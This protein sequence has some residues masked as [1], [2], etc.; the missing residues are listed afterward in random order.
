V[1]RDETTPSTLGYRSSGQRSPHL[2]IAYRRF[3]SLDAI[4]LL[5]SMLWTLA[6]ARSILEGVAQ[7]DWVGVVFDSLM[8][9]LGVAVAS[10]FF[11]KLL[12]QSVIALDLE[13]ITSRRGPFLRRKVVPIGQVSQLV[14]T[15]QHND[16][17][18]YSYGLLLQRRDGTTTPLLEPT[19]SVE[20]VLYIQRLIEE[21]LRREA[22]ASLDPPSPNGDWLEIEPP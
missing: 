16:V 20:I 18:G 22:H 21:H 1:R 5:L 13:R 9:L 15:I 17:E 14:P 4:V 11:G 8:A 6:R 12:V 7:S 2:S 3:T 19:S 10:L